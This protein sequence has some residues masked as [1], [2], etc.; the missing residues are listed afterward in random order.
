M[1]SNL[2]AL[3]E[4]ISLAP[5]FDYSL[6]YFTRPKPDGLG[7]DP[8]SI[9]SFPDEERYG[10][11]I[12]DNP[13]DRQGVGKYTQRYD[14]ADLNSGE[15]AEKD[16]LYFG[17]MFGSGRVRLI[18]KSNRLLQQEMINAF[19]FRSPLLDPISHE[20]VQRMGG[21]GSYVA[22][23]ARVGD[24]G[25]RR[26]AAENMQ[27]VFKTFASQVGSS[28]LSQAFDANVMLQIGF[29]LAHDTNSATFRSQ[30]RPQRRQGE[31]SSLYVNVKRFQS[32]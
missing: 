31:E 18:E 14:I 24:G 4:S 3:P 2:D 5:R 9:H 8:S 25:F 28:Y 12:Y 32:Y 21:R 6:D 19:V 27:Q 22:I 29:R 17:S 11:R 1:L 16:L 13:A 10:I 7:L 20:I 23:H 30:Q 26:Q 15:F